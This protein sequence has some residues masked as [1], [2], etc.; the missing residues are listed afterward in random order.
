MENGW[1]SLKDIANFVT[2]SNEND[3]VSKAIEKYVLK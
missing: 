3:G 2:D 1:Q